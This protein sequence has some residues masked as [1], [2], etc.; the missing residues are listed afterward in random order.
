MIK[1]MLKILVLLTTSLTPL[2]H[3][4][5]CKSLDYFQETQPSNYQNLIAAQNTR[6]IG[7][8]FFGKVLLTTYS[9]IPSVVK[10]QNFANFSENNDQFQTA[11]LEV[12]NLATFREDI[13]M[14]ERVHRIK[15]ELFH[16]KLLVNDNVNYNVIPNGEM[17]LKVYDFLNLLI[18]INEDVRNMTPSDFNFKN[19]KYFNMD[20]S[21]LESIS[22][23]DYGFL[24]SFFVNFVRD[25]GELNLQRFGYALDEHTMK[26]SMILQIYDCVYDEQNLNLF[27]FLEKLEDT[28]ENQLQNFNSQ[29]SSSGRII[30]Y[31]SL[32]YDLKKLHEQYKL[33]HND[34]KPDNIMVNRPFKNGTFDTRLKLIDYGLMTPFS[35]P[36][37]NFHRQFAHPSLLLKKK[38]LAE[39]YMD[40]YSFLLTITVAEYGF[41]TIDV[42][43]N[44]YTN[45]T[46]S[47]TETLKSQIILAFCNKTEYDS[48]DRR[49]CKDPQRMSWEYRPAV[50]TVCKHLLCFLISNLWFDEEVMIRKIEEDKRE[51][52]NGDGFYSD[53]KTDMGNTLTRLMKL[54]P[55]GY[56]TSRPVEGEVEDVAVWDDV[57]GKWR[58]GD[59]EWEQEWRPDQKSYMDFLEEIRNDYSYE[60]GVKNENEIYII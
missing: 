6:P 32:Y 30:S 47:C 38:T 54:A 12:K 2:S 8:G 31:R 52:E 55:D 50:G 1:N 43:P 10:I 57:V 53:G 34:I 24:Q 4:R 19:E 23:V 33:I 41:P 7:E 40:I 16:K 13:A 18:D 51:E 15:G 20:V 35:K 27:I 9:N 22:D 46:P 14:V 56:F 25:Y 5:L 49:V 59:Y 48:K 3:T 60:L 58:G 44:C 28:F 42:G 26:E 36:L 29:I 21:T 11:L 39:P 17:K 37:P 45:Y